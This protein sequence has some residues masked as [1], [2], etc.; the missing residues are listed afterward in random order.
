MFRMGRDLLRAG[1]FSLGGESIKGR[2]QLVKILDAVEQEK[3]MAA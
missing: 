2:E 3:E 1:R